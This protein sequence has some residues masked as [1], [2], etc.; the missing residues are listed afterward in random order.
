MVPVGTTVHVIYEPIK[1]GWG[2]GK[3]WVQVFDDFDNRIE[4][5]VSKVLGELAYYDTTMGPLE[6]DFKA[7]SRAL[8][9]KTGVPV[10]IAHPKQP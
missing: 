6:I 9:D 4:N 2:D 7:L 1:V 3:C 5:P 10:A 8:K